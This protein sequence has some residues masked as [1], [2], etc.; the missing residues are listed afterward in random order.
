MG[1]RSNLPQLHLGRSPSQSRIVWLSTLKRDSMMARILMI[2]LRINWTN[3]MQIVT[4]L[5]YLVIWGLGATAP[6][7]AKSLHNF[8]RKFG[9]ISPLL[10]LTYFWYFHLS[11][12]QERK[13]RKQKTA[14]TEKQWFF[15]HCSW[16]NLLTA[17]GD[18][19]VTTSVI[20]FMEHVTKFLDQFYFIFHN[21]EANGN[22]FVKFCLYV[23]SPV[24]V[25]Q[26]RN[27][28]GT[29][30]WTNIQIVVW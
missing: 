2:S 1:K 18:F 11:A 10:L 28:G 22:L 25:Q 30:T 24:L 5:V 20:V 29:I 26:G 7:A 6:K 16:S 13:N 23:S 14:K 19:D 9:R 17:S 27:T 4:K 3:F 21:V 8:M 12:V 15:F